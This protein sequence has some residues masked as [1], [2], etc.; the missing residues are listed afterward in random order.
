MYRLVFLGSL[1]GYAALI[2]GLHFITP[3]GNLPHLFQSGIAIYSFIHFASFCAYF[4]WIQF[5]LGHIAPAIRGKVSAR[6]KAA[7]KKQ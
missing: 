6:N 3:P 7:K 1:G 4:H 2:G 5:P